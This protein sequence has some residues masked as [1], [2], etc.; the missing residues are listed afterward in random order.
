MQNVTITELDTNLSFEAKI[1]NTPEIKHN[2]TI[3]YVDEKEV[4]RPNVSQINGLLEIKLVK[5]DE[6][7]SN[8]VKAW[9]ESRKR[10]NLMIQNSE[11]MY[12]MKGCSVKKFHIS[13]NTLVVFYNSFKEA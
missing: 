2:Y 3:V 13:Q 4:K 10:I 5:P 9:Y 11:H 7:V 6:K 8:F 1:D 12:F